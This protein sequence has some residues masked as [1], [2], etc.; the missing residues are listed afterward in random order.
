M[1]DQEDCD[2][3]PNMDVGIKFDFLLALLLTL[4]IMANGLSKAVSELQLKI[5][6]A[7]A[8]IMIRDDAKRYIF[9]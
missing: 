2:I 7:Y 3:N 4:E 1:I 8:P 6:K 9:K 5:S